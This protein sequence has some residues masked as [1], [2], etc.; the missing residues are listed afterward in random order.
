MDYATVW[1][2]CLRSAGV[3]TRSDAER[4]SIDERDQVL[5][6]AAWGATEDQT[7]LATLDLLTD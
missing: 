7:W 2:A 3:T 1:V 4:L 6:V 5:D